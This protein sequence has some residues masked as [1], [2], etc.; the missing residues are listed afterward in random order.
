MTY[1]ADRFF[2]GELSA[3]IG[4]PTQTIRFYERRGLIRQPERTETGYRLYQQEDERRVRF[5]LDAKRFGL[6]LDEIKDLIDIRVSGDAPCAHLKDL[7][8]NHLDNVNQR[9]QE[10]TSLRDSLKDRYEHLNEADAF[11]GAICGAIEDDA[12]RGN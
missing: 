2:I 4:V 5:I 11:P 8:R 12:R 9:I 7:L 6:S 10:L 1:V 3:R